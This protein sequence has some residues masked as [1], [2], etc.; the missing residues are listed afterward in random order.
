MSTR[1]K[2]LLVKAITF[3]EAGTHFNEELRN[4]NYTHEDLGPKKAQTPADKTGS[5]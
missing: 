4:V 1:N 3:G 5:T 2:L